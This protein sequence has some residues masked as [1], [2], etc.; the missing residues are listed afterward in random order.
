MGRSE[1]MRKSEFRADHT[2]TATDQSEV[3]QT[4]RVVGRTIGLILVRSAMRVC[5]ISEHPPGPAHVFSGTP[6]YM[7]AA[8]KGA[9]D[10][11]HFVQVPPLG[12]SPETSTAGQ[13]AERLR[14]IG[15]GASEQVNSLEVDAVICQ[16]SSMVPYLQT[17]KKVAVW[18][19]STWFALKRMDFSMFKQ[20]FPNLFQWDEATLK[21]ADLCAFPSEWLR[22]QTASCYPEH[23]ARLCV[24]PFGAN[25]LRLPAQAIEQ[26]VQMRSHSECNLTFLGLDWEGKGLKLVCE[27][28]DRLNEC[29][30]PTSL[31]V[32]GGS[33][34]IP[35]RRW[36]KDLFSLDTLSCEERAIIH[37][38]LRGRVH[39]QGFLDKQDNAHFRR[40]SGILQRT[41]F[42]MHPARFECF[43]IAM[44]EANAFGVPVLATRN[45]GAQT[46]V[47]NGRNG[48]LF[49]RVDYV[50]EATETILR[51]FFRYEVYA[52]L[53]L[54]A[55]QEYVERLNWSTAAR[56]LIQ[57][58]NSIP[59]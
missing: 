23:R 9:V 59:A 26:Q 33:A 29:E 51:H 5:F 47:R 38:W 10:S 30:L 34:R 36:I 21:I 2:K 55:H 3:E 16:G 13:L 35:V 12:L 42:L 50:Q 43:G 19:D 22:E 40:L 53:A 24:I 25:L 8:I 7:A 57:Q 15:L 11:F 1:R 6:H 39:L 46:I 28:V 56:A 48:F 58:L 45:H 44:V 27:V 20:T 41:H 49:N 32:I 31:T 4:E 14:E 37:L 17:E 54:S 52:R 18:H